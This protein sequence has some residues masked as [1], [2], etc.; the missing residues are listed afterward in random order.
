MRTARLNA[1]LTKEFLKKEHL[2]NRKTIS[3]IAREVGCNHKSVYNYLNI[4]GL[5]RFYDPNSHGK[6]KNQHPKWKGFKEISAT[7]WNNVLNGAR[8][9]KI[10]VEITIEEAWELFLKQNRK[11]SLSNQEIGFEACK[12]NTAS[13]DRIDSKKGY[14]KGNL[15]WVH[16]DINFAKQSLSNEEFIDL[17]NSVVRHNRRQSSS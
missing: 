13:L 10:R 1:I 15:Q 7:Y 3:Q 11:C 2:D 14:I 16:R 17:C 4:Y 9:R 8:N 12:S 5:D 6:S